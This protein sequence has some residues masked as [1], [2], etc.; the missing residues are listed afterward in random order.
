MSNPA[1]RAY[2]PAYAYEMAAIIKRGM[3]EM[4]GEDKDVIYYITAYN[5]N[6]RDA[7]QGEGR[8]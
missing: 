6:S 3:E 7:R 8:R 4:H 5:E 2:D 1:V